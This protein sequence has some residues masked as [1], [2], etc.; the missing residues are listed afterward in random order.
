MHATRGSSIRARGFVIAAVLVAAAAPAHANTST[1]FPQNS[2]IIPTGS[3][4]QDDCGAVSAYGL[5]YDVLR[6]NPWLK[7]NGYAPISVFYVYLDTKQSPN[8]CVPTSKDT[9]PATGTAASWSDGCDIMGVKP[10]LI[11][12]TNHLATAAKVVTYT[13]TSKANVFPQ[14]PTQTVNPSDL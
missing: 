9:P 8:R 3:S 2:L 11:D 5:V 10:K 12:N 4:F 13:T 6:A 1:A 7:A 14:Y